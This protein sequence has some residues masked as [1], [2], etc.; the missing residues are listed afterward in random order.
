MGL[1]GTNRLAAALVGFAVAMVA[2]V[3]LIVLATA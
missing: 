2:L 3:A 1:T